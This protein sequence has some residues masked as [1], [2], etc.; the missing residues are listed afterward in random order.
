MWLPFSS[1]IGT[2]TRYLVINWRRP[3]LSNVAT[4]VECLDS[5]CCRDED[6]AIDRGPVVILSKPKD[7]TDRLD[8]RQAV[9]HEETHFLALPTSP[10]ERWNAVGPGLVDLVHGR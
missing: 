2:L 4:L 6:A 8:G 1:E 9:S 10:T 7:E 3:W 5:R